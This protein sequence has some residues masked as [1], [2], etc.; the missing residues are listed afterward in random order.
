[1]KSGINP[2]EFWSTIIGSIIIAGADELG[3]PL[4]ETT[5]TAIVTMIVACIF[6][7]IFNKKVE[8][9]EREVGNKR[10]AKFRCF[11]LK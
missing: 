9:G 6:G 3:I 11:V 4:S 5:V 8:L 7:R 2:P 1:M 10:I